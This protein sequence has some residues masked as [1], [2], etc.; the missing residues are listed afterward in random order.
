MA[1]C[2]ANAR[3]PSSIWA[4]PVYEAGFLNGDPPHR[5]GRYVT[6]VD[7]HC[8]AVSEAGQYR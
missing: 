3:V 1:D 8:K 4:I 7:G 5:E 2:S 6:F